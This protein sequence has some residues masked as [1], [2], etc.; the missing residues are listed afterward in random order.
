MFTLLLE[1]P[2]IFSFY[3]IEMRKY[4]SQLIS[5]TAAS[6]RAEQFKG[7]ALHRLLSVVY[8]DD[9]IDIGKAPCNTC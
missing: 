4:N 7:G 8:D 9:H 6:D 3:E 1:V 5:M 2:E